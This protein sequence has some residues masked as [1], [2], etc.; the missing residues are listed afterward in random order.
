MYGNPYY[1]NPQ[2]YQPN[3]PLLNPQYNQISSQP[4]LLGKVVESVD[5]VKV[6]DIP[7]DGSTS[8]FPLSDSSAIVT[9]QLQM[10][11]TSKIVVYK[12][13]PNE[14]QKT[15]QFATIDELQNAIDEINNIKQQI[16]MLTTPKQVETNE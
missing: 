10:D 12:P 8:Y 16:K 9:K 1:N 5:I 14:E 7:L 6:L 13:V 4:Q 11:G 2:R 3:M 15:V